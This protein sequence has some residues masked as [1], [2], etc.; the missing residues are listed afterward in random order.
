MHFESEFEQKLYQQR[1]EKLQQ[2]AALGAENGLN[3]AQA[4]YPNSF[5]VNA[6]GWDEKQGDLIPWIKRQ[7]DSTESPVSGEQLEADHK[8]VAIAGRIMAIRLQGKAGFAQLQQGGQRLQIYVR[9]DDVGENAFALYKLL[10]L[11]DHIGIRGYLMR[12]RTGELTV[13]VTSAPEQTGLAFLA[14]AMLALPDK[15]HGLEDTEL[16]YRQRYV[17]LFMNTGHS[18]KADKS[19]NSASTSTESVSLSGAAG[20]VEG[21]AVSPAVE[22]EEVPRNVRE[23]FVKRAAVLRALRKFF[24]ARG[25]LEVETPMMQQIA[26][27]AAARPFITHH[28]ELDIDLFLRIAPELYLKR[29]VVGGLDRVYEIN[30][31]F[32]NEGVS[33]RHNPEFTMLEFYQ[34]YANYH[35]LMDLTE[36]LIKF[37]AMEVNGTTITHF[38]GNEINLGNWTKLSMREAIIKWWPKA[39]GPAPRLEDFAAASSLAA[40]FEEAHKAMEAYRAKR[41]ETIDPIWIEGESPEIQEPAD[42]QMM[43][44]AW[45][46][47]LRKYPDR[48]G[49]MIAD[50]FELLAEKHLIQP[51]IIYDFPLAVSPLSKVKP[52]EPDWVERFEFYIGGFEVGNA[53]SE[54]NDPVDQDNRFQQ[55]IEQKE[56][57]D[58]EAM[59]AVDDDYV[60]ALGYGLPPTAGEGIGIDR[61]TMLLT[62][63]SSIRDVIL[64]PLMRPRQKTAEQVAQKEE[65][66]HGESTE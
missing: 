20:E 32:R 5:T 19:A 14:K 33:T 66:P 11:G 57:G 42:Q 65:Q 21:S 7:F 55:Q 41:G 18:A 48:L 63:S 15:Y 34:A 23:V 10:D 44:E 56:K 28:N 49:K 9:K 38:N 3:P 58:E 45:G 26:G 27:G 17:D 40:H 8:Q 6:L 61:L 1:Q 24:D 4:T 25:Y 43:F 35:D 46:L 12:T 59:S 29:L 64:F 2:I 30:R 62:N 31:N 16:R 22:T 51:T 47:V 50:V 54:L 52:E 36:E 37:V 53:F 13:H 60:R 39:A